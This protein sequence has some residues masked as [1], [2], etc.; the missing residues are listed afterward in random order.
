[1]KGKIENIFK[2]REV[3]KLGKIKEAAVMILI[4][5]DG[6]KLNV[7]FEVR[8]TKLKS[9]PG[10][11]CFPGG[12]IEVGETPK[13]AA[14]RETMEEL[15]LK[16]DDINYIGQMDDF[17][18]PYGLIIYTFVATT[19]VK[20]IYPSEFEVDKILKL[21]LVELC[22]YEPKLYNMNIGPLNKDGFPFE[23]INGGE[24]YKFR[25]GILE[26]YFYTFNNYTIW[27]YTA[28]ILKNFL[29]I[30]KESEL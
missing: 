4:Q 11:I 8:S 2:N 19:K 26:Q 27:G 20:K 3:G 12:K 9:Q 29:D 28:Y 23:L 15:N 6:E 17:I 30:I 5:E 14:I 21:D 1:M 18:T 24:S 25:Q 22:Q 10:D 13:M 16:K 7:I